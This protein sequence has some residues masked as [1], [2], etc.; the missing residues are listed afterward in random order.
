MGILKRAVPFDSEELGSLLYEEARLAINPTFT[1]IS[2]L[3]NLPD[4]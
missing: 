1:L 2:K 3:S 4:S